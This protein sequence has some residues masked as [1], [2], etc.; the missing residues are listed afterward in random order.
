VRADGAGDVTDTHVAW[1]MRRGAPL[2][3][4]PLLVGDELY[5]VNDLGIATCLDAKTGKVHWQQRLGGN[6]SASPTFADGRIYFL[7]EEGIAT[8]ISPGK[9][10]RKL[11][12]N[13]L[14][15]ATLASMAVSRR[16]I[17]IRSYTH[18]YR[19]AEMP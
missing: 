17:F 11:A 3:P 8:V 6:Y 19:I 18:L 12:A 5:V 4:S 15:G 7:S 1:A 13:E 9:E 2:T 14:D 16:S 10:F